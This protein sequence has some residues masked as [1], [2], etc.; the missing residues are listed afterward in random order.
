MR[1]TDHWP[2]SFTVSFE[3]DKGSQLVFPSGQTVAHAFICITEGNIKVIIRV[4]YCMS[5]WGCVLALMHC[6]HSLV[7]TISSCSVMK[8]SVSILLAVTHIVSVLFGQQSFSLMPTVW[9]LP[10]SHLAVF[11]L[12]KRWPFGTHRRKNETISTIVSLFWL[13]EIMVENHTKEHAS[14]W[15][16]HTHTILQWVG[17]PSSFSRA[18]SGTQHQEK[19]Y[20]CL[21]S[22]PLVEES[23]RDITKMYW[24]LWEKEKKH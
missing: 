24:W 23:D 10:A 21:T 4:W 22:E 2:E 1:C 12:Q 3:A 16:S 9:Q 5:E 20:N 14:L 11:P 8:V 19:S 6:Y 18:A 13:W 15:H 17:D 7:W